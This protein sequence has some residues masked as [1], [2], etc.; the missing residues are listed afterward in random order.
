M[1]QDLDRVQPIE[2]GHYWR[3]LSR[4]WL[5]VAA[6]VVF[7]LVAGGAY[8]SLT[9]RS[10]TATAVV[11]L[12][13]IS[14]QPFSNAKPA[15]QLI[16]PQTEV[17]LATSSPVLT[18]VLRDLGGAE[19]LAQL[20]RETT[21][22]A[23]ANT[24]VVQISFTDSSKAGAVTGA[25]EIARGYLAYRSAAAAATVNKVV[26][27]LG[28]Q[29]ALLADELVSANQR[30]ANAKA[31]SIAA[32]QADSDRQ[33]VNIELTSLLGQIDQLDS[34]DTSGGTL[35]NNAHDGPVVAGPAGK[36]VLISAG[37]LGLILGLVGAFVVQ[38]L[39]RRIDTDAT[40][41]AA[42]GG[43]VLSRLD[44]SRATV[45]A[46]GSDLD[47]F[48]SLREQLL[49]R[50]PAGASLAFV[51][52]TKGRWPSDVGINLAASMAELAR[53]A[54]LVLVEYPDDFLLV[55]QQELGLE[56]TS[57]DADADGPVTSY[58]S[59]VLPD[60][61]VLAVRRR[62][63]EPTA[64]DLVPDL[65]AL[66][67]RDRGRYSMSVVCLPSAAARSLRLSAARLGHSVVLV[68]TRRRTRTAEVRRL[69]DELDAVGAVTV[70]SVLVARSRTHAE[71][72][73]RSGRSRAAAAVETKAADVPGG[74]AQ[75]EG[76]D[77]SLARVATE[78]VAT[79]R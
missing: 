63:G 20:R 46:T 48:R 11:N 67:H 61:T 21:V 6:G 4:R 18:S 34:V 35:I 14:S 42:G 62:P 59:A 54:R 57:A 1:D 36:T 74:T 66:L 51:D 43:A 31:G 72:A 41:S 25:N 26:N 17:R 49:V 23:V 19:S 10:V 50:V 60:L 58:S 55:L 32:A 15:S 30:L 12:N 56:S 77:R 2:V 3:V 16:D 5:V 27:Q 29:Q 47:A 8:L 52:L 28:K 65:T 33:L 9:P 39:D 38:A 13:V 78:P 75:P 37:L 64:A 40:V 68:A 69:A 79:R 45:P 44:C 76:A 53:P 71:L 22:V 24:T 70:G 73:G 7:G